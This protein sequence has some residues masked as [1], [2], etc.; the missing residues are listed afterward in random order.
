MGKLF[1]LWRRGRARALHPL[2]AVGLSTLAHSS[3]DTALRGFAM[4][5][6]VWCWVSF[7][8]V[9]TAHAERIVNLAQII[10]ASH[11]VSVAT[12]P[13]APGTA[14]K[15]QF[16]IDLT[17]LWESALLTA[18]AASESQSTDPEV[19]W[20]LDARHFNTMPPENSHNLSLGE[21]IVCRITMQIPVD[22]GDLF[23]EIPMPR[24]DAAHFSYR[25][26]NGGT[27]SPWVRMSAGDRIPMQR[28]PVAYRYPAF[29][30]PAQAGQVQMVMELAHQGLMRTPMLLSS[31]ALFRAESFTSALRIGL[32][33]GIN[34]VLAVVAVL[35]A[36]GFKRYSF[37]ALAALTLCIALTTA[38]VSGVM[39]M[40]FATGSAHFNDA[41]KFVATMFAGAILPWGVA[42]VVAQ[43]FHAP[44]V[45][46]VAQAWAV[47]AMLWTLWAVTQE[48]RLNAVRFA[49][50]FL[51]LSMGFALAQ[52]F[53]A[54]ARRHANAVAATLGTLLYCAALLLPLL[55]YYGYVSTNSSFYLATLTLLGA[56]VLFLHVLI[57]QHRQGRTVT[58]SAKSM[59]GRDGLTG[60]HNIRGFENALAR[61]VLRLHADNTHAAFFYIEV[62]SAEALRER[63]GDEGFEVGLVQT[64]AAL[65]SCV[66]AHDTVG[67]VAENGF[68]VTVLMPRDADIANRIATQ[69]LARV[70]G[71]ALHVAPLAQTARIALAWVPGHGT[72]LQ[73]LKKHCERA[74][75]NMQTEKRI[76]WV[77]AEGGHSSNRNSAPPSSNLQS[78]PLPDS[79]ARGPASSGLLSSGDFSNGSGKQAGNGDLPSIPGVVKPAQTRTS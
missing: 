48:T 43:K 40:Y 66:S 15:S 18:Q 4:Q 49:L 21:R 72:T 35:A 16:S 60:L 45:W 57:A 39:G 1:K 25:Y 74:L 37:F 73:E 65:S 59:E 33:G 52:A 36:V 76:G 53:T 63:Y 26:V 68:A 10:Q 32:L 50:V 3:V 34:V 51:F 11:P 67:R 12:D 13:A 47:T 8:C 28:W 46:R 29:E 9:S 20:A 54:L 22:L 5:C 70:M 78:Q 62:A 56:A 69:M 27:V 14:S 19:L 75:Q 64:A 7:L 44:W 61:T 24:L 17:Q 58:T 23:L 41:I 2:Q 30:I 31:N 42:I 77:K 71:L 55:A 6:V 38:A 79:T